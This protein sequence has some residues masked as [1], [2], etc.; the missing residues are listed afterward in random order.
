M[1]LSEV[2]QS[3]S[4]IGFSKVSSWELKGRKGITLGDPSMA[5]PNSVGP[6]YQIDLTENQN[7][8][9]SDEEVA[10][11]ERRFGKFT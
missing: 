7:P 4:K 8:N 9:L 3:L 1:Y 11:I 2:L 5:F 10:A 6:R